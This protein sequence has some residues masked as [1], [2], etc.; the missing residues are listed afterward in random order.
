[1]SHLDEKAFEVFLKRGG[2]SQSAVKRVIMQVAE[3]E[4][5]MREKRGGKGLD[6]AASEDLEAFVLHV[7]DKRKGRAKLYLWSIHY[8]YDYTQNEELRSLAGRLR[9]QR[10]KRKP[11]PLR[12]F[13]G[14]SPVH[15][16]KLGALGIRNAEEM[17]DS[18]RTRRGREELSTKTG[19]SAEAVLELVKLSDLAR[20]QGVKSVRARL[21][22]DA[23][24]D[25]VEKMASWDPK[26]LRAMLIHFV[27][28]TSFDGIAPLPK[29]A[30]FTVT[31]A[32]KLPKIVEC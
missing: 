16:E 32:K 28:K 24:V 8:Y 3:F 7:E 13:R 20:I 18:G 23:G 19:I 26:K 11:F 1:V 9:Q 5:Y 27:E 2:R 29:E 4:W 21:Y 10:I 30:E 17:L 25:T 12:D 31:E 14:I 6:E 15:I 22:Y